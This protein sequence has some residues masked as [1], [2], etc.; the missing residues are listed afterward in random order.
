MAEAIPKKILYIEDDPDT[1]SLMGDIIRYKGYTF[2]EAGRGLEGIR[3][4]KQKKPDLILVD[5]ILPDMQGYEVT[6]HLRGIADLK[7][8]PIIALTGEVSKEIRELTLTAGCVGYIT[9]PINVTE[10]LFKIEEFLSGKKELIAPEREKAFLQKYN[11]QLVEKLRGKILE[12]E[13]MNESLS[14]L[15][16]ELYESREEFS[17]YNDWLF[18][19][20]NLANILRTQSDPFQML[21]MLPS[22]MTEGFKIDRC[23]LFELRSD[24]KFVAPFAFSG[25]A[26][27]GD[28]KKQYKISNE[29][30]EHI[31]QE[32]GMLWVK[33]TSG[34]L[35]RSMLKLADTLGT[36][37]FIIGSLSY[38]SPSSDST[39]LLR[40]IARDVEEDQNI[41]D[42][43]KRYLIFIDKQRSGS[44]FETYEIR[45][46][47]AFIQTVSIIFENMVLYYDLVKLFRL[48]EKQAITDGLTQLYNYR[49]FMNEISR[50]LKRSQRFNAQFSL[51]M[52][53]IDHFKELNDK[54]GHLVGDEVLQR[55]AA[56]FKAN[57]RSIDSASRYGGEEF[58]IIVPGIHK[59]NAHLMAEKLR[60]IVENQS[61]PG[62][63]KL[64]SKKLTISIGVASYPDD[65][66]TVKEIIRK[67]DEALYQAKER[68]RNRVI[69]YQV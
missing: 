62:Q 29:F 30:L 21:K 63:R 36:T 51:L 23:I 27:K 16:M 28:L 43:P 31:R 3:L 56:L 22:K 59:K 32:N 40:S 44:H 24:K 41:T 11:A 58:A 7:D 12:L 39:Q 35:D 48:K 17:K 61:V 67:A 10:F 46:L 38:F 60:I 9:K 2:Y 50:E 13:Q 26:D 53:D 18:Y 15:N 47:T 14:R 69:S 25:I 34:I 68:G 57:T 49:F 8:T 20:N 54:L 37:T 42:L 33:N 52:I 19:L 55:L 45:I 66:K 1:R 5:L 65:G 4:A 6:T 64:S